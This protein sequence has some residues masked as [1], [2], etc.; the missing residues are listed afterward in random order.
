LD[1]KELL[2]VG[3]AHERMS[4]ELQVDAEHIA[5]RLQAVPDIHS[6]KW[7]VKDPRN[8]MAKIIRKR[9]ERPND[10][11]DLCDYEK[12]VT[13]LIGLRALHL[14]KYQWVTIHEFVMRTWD[15]H[16]DPIAY[17]RMGDSETSL[18]EL[19]LKVKPHE[20][21]YR[22]VHYLIKFSPTRQ[23]RLAE[24]QV[25]TLFEE[26]WSEIDHKVRY[27]GHSDD[28]VLA[29]F[30]SV[31]NRL[32]GSADEMGSFVI[33]LRA[34][35]VEQDRQRAETEARIQRM[36]EDLKLSAAEK[37]RLQAE[38]DKLKPATSRSV[39][40]TGEGLKSGIGS[41]SFAIDKSLVDDIQKQLTEARSMNFNFDEIKKQLA[42]A[43]SMN[44]D[45]DAIKKQLAAAG[46]AFASIPRCAKCG[47]LNL[48]GSAGGLCTSCLLGQAS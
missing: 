9:I 12:H 1:W 13:D 38:I 26:G 15:L 14:L 21:N 4:Q 36:V 11:F 3:V 40:L 29:Q 25:R 22:S 45:F 48:G 30:L 6:L 35:Q 44:F 16:E 23:S 5:R 20:H 42:D 46:D 31:F 2:T 28:A 43:R 7:R 8:L 47:R 33:A 27:P 24:L 17:I 19:G 18:R 39:P 32:A 37:D 34:W 10:R 41:L